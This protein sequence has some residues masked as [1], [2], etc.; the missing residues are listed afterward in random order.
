MYSRKERN[1]VTVLEKRIDI[2]AREGKNIRSELHLENTDGRHVRGEIFSDQARIV[3]AL[4]RFVNAERGYPIV[5]GVD[6]EGLSAGDMISGQI[7]LATDG[8]EVSVPVSVRIMAEPSE[9][10]PGRVR[11]LR[12][13]A[14]LAER[15]PQEAFRVF[16]SRPFARLAAVNGAAEDAL[17]RG[18][19]AAPV[20]EDRMEEFL[21]ASGLKTMVR[22][23][24]DRERA[25][26][27]QVTESMQDI[28]LLRRNT[29]G[30]IVIDIEVSGDF[31]E[32]P[33]RRITEEDFV[34]ST[35]EL[36]YRVLKPR[37][38]DGR[39]FGKITLVI[40]GHRTDFLVTASAHE[41]GYSSG[42]MTIRRNTAQLARLYTDYLCGSVSAEELADRS[43]PLLEE[44]AGLGADDGTAL[45][46]YRAYLYDL[47]G[48]R[49]EAVTCIKSLDGCD[50][51]TESPEVLGAY[52][53]L[54][55]RTGMEKP[56]PEELAERISGLFLRRQE[57][58]VCM[59]LCMLTD[60]DLARNSRRLFAMADTLAAH[61]SRSPMLY[62]EV[63][64]LLRE[65]DSRLTR[66]TPLMEQVL[67]FAA[68]RNLMTRELALRTAYLSENL[69][70][71]SENVYR[72]LA[73]AYDSFPMDSILE[74]IVRLVMKG[75]PRNRRYF[76]WYAEA[77][78]KNLRIIRLY[79]YY[80]E[81][82][83]ESFRGL[84]PLAVRKYF[85]YNN[86]LSDSGKAFVY[87]NIVRH[88][89][90]DPETYKTYSDQME[91]FAFLALERGKTG[92]D[93][94]ALYSWFVHD[95]PDGR[96]G[97]NLADLLFTERVYTD[98]PGICSVIVIHS[99]LRREDRY[100]LQHGQAFI[101]RYTKDAQILFET[102]SSMRLRTPVAYSTEPLLYREAYIGGC[103]QKF[104]D[105]V[106]IVM[107]A[108][109]GSGRKDPVAAENFQFWR[110]AAESDAFTDSFRA[111]ARRKLL[112]FYAHH[113]EF[114]G[115]GEKVR[116]EDLWVRT[117]KAAYISVLLSVGQVRHAYDLLVRYGFEKVPADMLVRVASQMIEA[118]DGRYDEEL[119]LL[120]SYVF[121][122]DK[123][124][125]R[126]LTYLAEHYEGSMEDMLT[127]RKHA[128]DFYVETFPLDEKILARAAFTHTSLPADSKVLR[129]YVE[130]GG[131]RRII[132]AYLET[133]ADEQ[134][135]KSDPVDAYTAGCIEDL[136][137]AGEPV[138]FAMK[139]MLL[140]R[141]S[142]M[143]R[144]SVHQEI[145]TDR[146]LEESE[147][148]GVRLVFF[149]N[150][151]A[152][153][154]AQYQ[155][156]DKV[157]V[158]TRANPDDTVILRYRIG[159]GSLDKVEGEW[160]SAALHHRF[161]GIFSREFTL[162]Y[163]EVLTYYI[164]I[165]HNGRTR[166]TE[167]ESAASPLMDFKGRSCY[168]RINQMLYDERQGLSG[169]LKETMRDYLKARHASSV[170][171]TL[172]DES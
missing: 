89:G 31:L 108:T 27:Y 106:G 36:E 93:Y 113:P 141:Y 126:I 7:T 154:P 116:D 158:E 140:R 123:Y 71:Y 69:R 62:A 104:P 41:E 24:M 56:D 131:Q 132:R 81:T 92:T 10:L 45:C 160:K 105:A 73:A 98:E 149:R 101:R 94:A 4:T 164:E 28:L 49:R 32:V 21:T 15:D 100:P 6:V 42:R 151:P 48:N 143:K 110:A 58:Y 117:D 14:R 61:G 145:L 30:H 109:A 99:G 165:T 142:E 37:L 102:A 20:T 118:S 150:L 168:Q 137:D 88:R 167:E 161:R 139:L 22:I 67:A 76:R 1:V 79:E 166:R 2:Q 46:L 162:F 65:D 25:D 82:I 128:E 18:L 172:E 5:F 35:C 127:L 144:L 157:I 156:E 136:I 80:I 83:P 53:Y 97:E 17:C 38:G 29:W 163:G 155:L 171:F 85:A 51:S 119:L 169:N 70:S 63:L 107:D 130:H 134:L 34:G 3:P 124:D 33:R 64:R 11:S 133:A 23:S 95:V 43:L 121:R 129:A 148:R 170:L 87:A 146:I 78:E 96:A 72:V 114:A 8:G 52:R 120:V 91:R 50:L 19:T 103:R 40:R 59:K 122:A 111:E 60:E 39:R 68:R 54:L 77:V 90:E 135:L 115:F 44:N 9:T 26:F 86:T 112:G 74:A 55:A 75:Q 138:D 152:P 57:S 12:D 47:T 84:L 153:F 159:T 147:K 125:E 13:F 66:L 16:R